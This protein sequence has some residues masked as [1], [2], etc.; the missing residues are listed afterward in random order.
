MDKKTTAT[1]RERGQVTIP[2]EVRKQAQLEEGSVVEFE[3]RDEGVL[4]R[5]KIAIAELE[6]DDAFIRDVIA[7]TTSGYE[8]LR[9]DSSAWEA[10]LAE[11]SVLEGSLADALGDE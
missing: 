8:S 10:E 5:P 7:S 1:I 3:V 6:L 9:A 4:L 11:R 2:A